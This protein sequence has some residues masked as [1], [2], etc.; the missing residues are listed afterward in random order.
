VTALDYSVARIAD[1]RTRVRVMPLL[2]SLLA[3][4]FLVAGSTAAAAVIAYRFA[5]AATQ[6]GY[7]DVRDRYSRVG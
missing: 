7:A 6:T 1:W 4:P 3:L 5:V 2:L